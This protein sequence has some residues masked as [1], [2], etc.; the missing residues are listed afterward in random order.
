MPKP[1]NHIINIPTYTYIGIMIFCYYNIMYIMAPLGKF[2]KYNTSQYS[3][4][5]TRLA[6]I[7]RHGS[8]SKILKTYA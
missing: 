7:D 6:Y 2:A 3:H 5:C 1:I 4:T 8:V